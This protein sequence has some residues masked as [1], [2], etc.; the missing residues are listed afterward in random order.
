MPD[1]VP[2]TV[3]RNARDSLHDQIHQH[4]RAHLMAGRFVPGQKLS[5]R[6]LA[7]EFKTSLIPVRDALNALVAQGALEMSDCAASAPIGQIGCFAYRR[8][9][10]SS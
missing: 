9:S 5:L 7:R 2:V 8:I 10:G 3:N 1:H 4:C 6:P